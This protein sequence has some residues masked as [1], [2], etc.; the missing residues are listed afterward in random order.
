MGCLPIRS[1][2]HH[3]DDVLLARLDGTLLEPI[4]IGLSTIICRSVE[5]SWQRMGGKLLNSLSVALE[6]QF[7]VKPFQACPNV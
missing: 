2:E 5:G 1:M 3:Q 4:N 7:A 6:A